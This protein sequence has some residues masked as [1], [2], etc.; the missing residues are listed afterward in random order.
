[1][2][3]ERHKYDKPPLLPRPKR[4]RLFQRGDLKYVILQY[5]KEKPSHGYEIIR[6][7]EE[8]FHGFY[9]PSPGTIYPTLQ[10]LEEMGYISLDEQ[11][12]EQEEKKV[13][14][15]T[16]KGNKFLAEQKEFGERIRK[17]I[18]SWWNPDNIDD[19]RKT[20]HEFDSLAQLV[21]ENVR[22][23]DR[24][25]LNRIREVISNAYEKLSSDKT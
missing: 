18:R 21:T 13:Y 20:M 23:A 2:E 8:R 19:I 7:L 14:T 4:E 25:K 17:Q 16:D 6:A 5:I 9:A 12:V 24:E 11:H 15:I 3:K 1:M 22:T 10:T